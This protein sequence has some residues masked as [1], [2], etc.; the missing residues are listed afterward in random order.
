MIVLTQIP[1]SVT[2][3][4]VASA[5]T[6]A[7][8][9]TACPPAPDNYTAFPNRCIGTVPPNCAPQIRFKMCTE[10]VPA[11]VAAALASCNADSRC[12]SFGLNLARN[13]SSSSS[14]SAAPARS[15]AAGGDSLC[16][17]QHPCKWQTFELGRATTVPN[18]AWVSYA[19]AGA[20]PTPT[21]GPSPPVPPH[22]R[23]APCSGSCALTPEVTCPY[24]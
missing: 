18:T 23:R 2:G 21:P 4:S 24:K 1:T 12:F 3:S 16:T 7:P 11:C 5:P 22:A 19:R 8:A 17:I 13:C 6:D 20:A 9:A 14:S 10:G 15:A